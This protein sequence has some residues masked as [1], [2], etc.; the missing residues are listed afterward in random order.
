MD[1]PVGF[2]SLSDYA[3]IRGIKY[4]A[5]WNR[6]KAGKIPGA[7]KINGEILV[8]KEEFADLEID[9][10]A[11][12]PDLNKVCVYARVS[13]PKKKDQLENQ[14]KRCSA[15]AE[16]NGYQI[17]R[18]AKER[19]SGLN[20]NR[21]VLNS[22]L[23]DM[24]YGTLIVEHKDRLTRYGFNQLKLLMEMTGREILV[25]NTVEDDTT[26]IINDLIS[27]I[28]SFSARLYGKRRSERAKT[29]IEALGLKERGEEK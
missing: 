5:A 29:A 15:W 17:V 3:R 28:Y 6:Y 19:G 14:A 7:T 13:D 23:K 20:D 1:R 9:Q 24:Q 2:L 27:I 25:I 11:V 26:D 8:S 4:Q 22:V 21:K 18:V 12:S 10:K 16:Q